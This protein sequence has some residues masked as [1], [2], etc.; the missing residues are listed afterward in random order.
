MANIVIGLWD[1]T[2][3][4]EKVV[5]IGKSKYDITLLKT[6]FISAHVL[7]NR[8][9]NTNKRVPLRFAGAV[10]TFEEF[11]SNMTQQDYAR[12]TKY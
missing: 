7:K 6:W 3:Y 2:R 11:P 9:G 4:N 1:P 8:N 10:S 12:L 5:D